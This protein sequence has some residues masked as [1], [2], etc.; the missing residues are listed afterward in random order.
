[1]KY[2][3]MKDNHK[4]SGWQTGVHWI[5]RLLLG[6]TFIW[7]SLD[8][9][10]NP[11]EFA[12]IIYGYGVFPEIT[13][14]AIAIFLPYVEC[15]T[16]ACLITGVLPKSSLAIIN[17]LLVGFIFLIGFNLFRGYSFDCG[18]F[19]VSDTQSAGSAWSLLI[20]DVLLLVA[21]IFLWA[22]FEPLGKGTP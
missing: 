20:R 9:I 14:N 4:K 8:K 7:A 17:G 21:G 11:A 15:I 10:V 2:P 3:K 16:G 6:L 1:L 13:I 18:C 5:L 22:R 19:S 12:R